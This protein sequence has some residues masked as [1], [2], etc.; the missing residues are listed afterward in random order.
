MYEFV[1]IIVL[2]GKITKI[3]G[4]HRVLQ[5][6]FEINIK[7]LNF[8]LKNIIRYLLVVRLENVTINAV[9]HGVR[10]HPAV[11]LRMSLGCHAC[12]VGHIAELNLE[13]RAPWVVCCPGSTVFQTSSVCSVVKPGA[14][15]S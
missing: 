3:T 15:G 5:I 11:I 8:K 6:N 4:Q 1:K 10:L 9:V 12:Y 2:L 13:P 14:T 7:P